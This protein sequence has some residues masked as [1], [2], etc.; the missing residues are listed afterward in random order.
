M[1]NSLLGKEIFPSPRNRK[2]KIFTRSHAGRQ[3][4]KFAHAFFHIS[5]SVIA[6]M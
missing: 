6:F 2:K 3:V 5:M 1:L 4:T